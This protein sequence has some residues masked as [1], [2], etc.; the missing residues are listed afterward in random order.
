MKKYRAVGWRIAILTIVILSLTGCSQP[1]LSRYT[2]SFVGKLDTV[3]QLTAYAPSEEVFAAACRRAEETLDQMDRLFDRY[4]PDSMVSHLNQT[5][6]QAGLDP[7]AAFTRLLRLTLDRQ[8]RSSGVNIA[9]GG[10]LSLWK[11]A[12]E[13]GLLPT[14]SSIT[15][16][17]AHSAPSVIHI[18]NGRV[19][20][21]DP[22]ASLDLG[23]VAKGFAADEVAAVLQDSGL[24]CFLLNCGSSTIVSS[25]TPPDAAGWRIA[26]KNP[27]AVLPLTDQTDPPSYLGTLL[28]ADRSLGVS[29]DYQQYF[30]QDGIYYSHILCPETGQPVRYYRQVCVLAP[31]GL[32]ADYYSTALFALPYEESR[33]AAEEAG[34]EALWIC[35][36][37]ALLSTDGF[38]PLSPT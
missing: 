20:L 2:A 30:C 4:D 19:S 9:M 24:S 5:A 37:G 14:N 17:L 12:R 38:P 34:L 13:T 28:L 33:A 22:Y 21:T 15:Q 35:S 16:A 1:A 8:Q 10:V 29:G 11:T 18:E 32:D 6:G 26:V 7:P 31:N 23:A 25:G 27:E 3:V 36:D